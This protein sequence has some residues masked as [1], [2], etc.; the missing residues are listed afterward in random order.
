MRDY[1]FSGVFGEKSSNSEIYDKVIGEA[2]E[3]AFMGYNSTLL[4][5]GITGSGKTFTVFGHPS[6]DKDR[7]LCYY[8]LD[9]LLH[10]Q[11]SME[12]EGGNLQI[13]LSFV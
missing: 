8:A 4:A 7:G 6:H 12:K 13:K 1:N 10:R 3:S 11:K 5:Y 9:H 2:V